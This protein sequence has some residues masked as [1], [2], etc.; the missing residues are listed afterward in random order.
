MSNNKIRRAVTIIDLH[1]RVCD[2]EG[3]QSK[4][5]A[6]LIRVDGKVERL[7]GKVDTLLQFAVEDREARAAVVQTS[8]Q[9]S[10]KTERVRLGSRAR[11]I[12]SFASALAAVFGGG[13]VAAMIHACS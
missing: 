7:D 12:I 5:S 6:S 8:L 13:V 4:M 1:E 2:L 10:G 3:A 11:I 9:E